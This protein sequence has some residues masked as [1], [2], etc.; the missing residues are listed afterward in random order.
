MKDKNITYKVALCGVLS[1]VAMVLMFMS[2]IIPFGTF[3]FPMLSGIML[4]AVVIEFN[5]KWAFA[6]YFAVSLLALLI[7]ADKEAV[8]YFIMFFGF[9]P[10]IKN[11]IE[12]LRSKSIQYV[13]KYAV[14]NVCII[15]A[16][17]AATFIFNV[18]AD[19][20][21]VFGFYVPWAFLLAGN[22][23]FLL[24]DR[25]VTVMVIYYVKKIRTKLIK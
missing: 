12:R 15:G 25:C 14:F 17:F 18:P 4:I 23:F 22:V 13:L 21:T 10:I 5:A 11:F 1:A 24:Y 20:F 3:A 16:F 2:G 6:V 19:S 7:S 8:V 9:Y